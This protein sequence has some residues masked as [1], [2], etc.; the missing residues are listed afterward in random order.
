[1]HTAAAPLHTHQDLQPHTFALYM[2]TVAVAAAGT[3]MMGTPPP[4]LPGFAGVLQDKDMHITYGG[5][6]FQ[7]SGSPCHTASHA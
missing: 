7:S 4:F 5:Q 6:D 3:M 2:L 1:M